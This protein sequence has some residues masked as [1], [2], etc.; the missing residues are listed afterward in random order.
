MKWQK[1]LKDDTIDFTPREHVKFFIA[2]LTEMDTVD[3]RNL[4]REETGFD[5]SRLNMQPKL[6]GKKKF[7]SIEKIADNTYKMIVNYFQKEIVLSIKLEG[8]GLKVTATH[9]GREMPL[10]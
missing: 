9:Q 7:T 5:I 4:V 3:F 2:R 10:G 1:I 6:M 8:R